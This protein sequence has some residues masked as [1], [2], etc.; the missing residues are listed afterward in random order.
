M[1][2]RTD[3]VTLP[4]GRRVP[5]RQLGW[6]QLRQSRSLAQ[7]QASRDLVAVGG[8]EFMREWRRMQADAE[9]EAA[10]K[11][12]AVTVDTGAAPP[13]VVDVLA[14]HDMLSVLICGIPTWDRPQIEDLDEADAETL[15][16]AILALT[17]SR[18]TEEQEKNAESPSTAV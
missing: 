8:A 12:Q 2:R 17:P 14:Q 16:R 18:R 15:A 1:A 11:D 6:L 5:I 4:D 3:T 10:A 7:T 9:A 13:A